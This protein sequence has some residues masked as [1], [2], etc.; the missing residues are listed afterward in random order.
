MRDVTESAPKNDPILKY[1]LRFMKHPLRGVASLP[2]WSWTRLLWLQAACAAVSGLLAALTKPNPFAILGGLILTPFISTMMVCLLTAFLYYYFQVFE[3]RTVKAS[4]LFTL[5]VFASLPFFIFQIASSLVP[6]VTL[7]G[8]AF[9]SMLLAVG[10]SETFLMEKRRAIRLAAILF[11]VVVLVWIGNKI[12]LYR[13]DRNAGA[14]TA[15][16]AVPDL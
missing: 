14:S 3:K 16:P 13:M 4:K 12:S 1:L 9:S 6:P 2:E 7:V 10:L 8:F 15:A 5:A 11:S